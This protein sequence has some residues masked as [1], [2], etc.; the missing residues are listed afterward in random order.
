[1]PLKFPNPTYVS[2]RAMIARCS[3]PYSNGWK[4]YGGRG[5]N[6]CDR[7]LK[8]FSN[9]VADMGCRPPGMEIGRIDNDG[10]YE[11]SNCQWQ[12]R[13]QN[14]R[15]KRTT[16][17]VIFGGEKMA[18]SEAIEK[19]GLNKSSVQALIRRGFSGDLSEVKFLPPKKLTPAAVRFI[20]TSSDSSRRLAREFKVSRTLIRM[21]KSGQAWKSLK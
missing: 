21:V 18:M 10:D 14:G 6:V 3:F 9:F 11:K 7:W 2:Y 16:R 1:M 5:I 13:K 20:R 12:T 19:T 17:Y 8:S 15:N 4:N